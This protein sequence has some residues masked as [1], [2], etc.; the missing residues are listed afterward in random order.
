M[1]GSGFRLV[2]SQPD[3][4]LYIQPPMLE[5]TVAI[6]IT[7]KIPCRNGLQGDETDGVS[8]TADDGLVLIQQSEI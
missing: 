6:H 2:I 4:A 7:A 1:R 5:T 8:A 3:A